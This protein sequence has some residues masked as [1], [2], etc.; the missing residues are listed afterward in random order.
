MKIDGDKVWM[1]AEELEAFR[2]Q[3][4]QT[5]WKI[6]HLLAELCLILLK[7]RGRYEREN[8]ILSQV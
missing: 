5:A 7:D 1:T 3:Q 2:E 6:N 8:G 4:L